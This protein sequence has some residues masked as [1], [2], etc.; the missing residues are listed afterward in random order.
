MLFGTW[1]EAHAHDPSDYMETRLK[2]EIV[3]HFA[4]SEIHFVKKIAIRTLN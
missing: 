3:N 2:T 1:S 4:N